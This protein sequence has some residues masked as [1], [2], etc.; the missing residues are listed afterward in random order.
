MSVKI[1]LPEA[2]DPNSDTTWAKY[3]RSKGWSNSTASRHKPLFRSVLI[4]LPG[5]RDRIIPARGDA[6]LRGEL[7]HDAPAIRP[8]RRPGRA[9]K[10]VRRADRGTRS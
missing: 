3:A 7:A 1:T 2:L 9:R 10:D 8:R 5:M 6:I 4:A